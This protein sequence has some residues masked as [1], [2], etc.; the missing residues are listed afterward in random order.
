L[1]DGRKISAIDVQ[2]LYLEAARKIAS[3]DPETIW[4]LAEWTS[5]LDDLERD[6]ALTRDRV[7]WV[8]KKHLLNAFRE[9][10]DLAWTDPWLQALDLE[11]HNILPDQGLFYDLV[12]QGAMR[13]LV[14]EEE[15]RDAIF[16]PPQTTRAYF[17]GRSV[18]RFNNAITSIQWDEITF[19]NGTRSHVVA[20]PEPAEGGRLEALNGL[21]GEEMAFSEFFRALERY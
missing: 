8:A 20:L 7:D 3:D 11:Y 18:A 9:K 4:L 16:T 5:V 17:R 19:S 21:L 1:N 13:S 14:R 2:R 15:I 6:V 12:Q 10:E